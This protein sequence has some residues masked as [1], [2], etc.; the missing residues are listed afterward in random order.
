LGAIREIVNNLIGAEEMDI[1]EVD[2]P[3]STLSPIDFYGHGAANDRKIRIGEGPIG[4]VALSGECYFRSGNIAGQKP[5]DE[6][7]PTACVPLKV[8]GLVFGVIVIVRLLPQKDDLVA[9]DYQLLELLSNQAGIALYC[10]KL[11][12]EQL[13]IAE[14]TA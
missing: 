2:P 4:R 9:L 12:A 7:K 6:H 10:A 3:T 13:A 11:R 14:F 1:F 8:D 5:D